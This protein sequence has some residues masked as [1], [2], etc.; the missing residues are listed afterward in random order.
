MVVGILPDNE[1]FD[2]VSN[3]S[4]THLELSVT[5]VQLIS[6]VQVESSVGERL[7]TYD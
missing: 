4:Q 6:P 2:V 7:I 5:D 3:T 1:M